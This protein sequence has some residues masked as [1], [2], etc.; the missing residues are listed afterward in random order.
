MQIP[1]TT[2]WR[3]AKTDCYAMGVP[4]DRRAPPS[5]R[6]MALRIDEPGLL[7]EGGEERCEDLRVSEMRAITLELQATGVLSCQELVQ[8]QSPKQ[9]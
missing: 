9:L 6:R 1:W 2:S 5:G 8:R 4:T 7:S 3:P